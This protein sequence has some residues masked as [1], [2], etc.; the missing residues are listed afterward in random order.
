M[1]NLGFIIIVVFKEII[2]K[3][4]DKFLF[5]VWKIVLGIKEM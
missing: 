1:M 4:F 5:C 2:V 3:N